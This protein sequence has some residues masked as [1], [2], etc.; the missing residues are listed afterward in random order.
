MTEEWKTVPGF[1]DY[2]VSSYGQFRRATRAQGVRLGQLIRWH[3]NVSTAYPVVRFTVDGKSH[4][5]NVHSCVASAFHGP[6]PEGMQ[7]RHLDGNPL[8]CRAENLCYGTAKENGQDKVRHG[9]SSAGEKNP[10]AKLTAEGAAA[11][12]AAKASGEPTKD[13]AAR[14]GLNPSTVYRITTGKYW[15]QEASNRSQDRVMR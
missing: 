6:K 8:N 12:R 14:L 10:K 11:V 5:R 3:T 9:R 15:S 4:A 13:I 7:V 1:I 2:E